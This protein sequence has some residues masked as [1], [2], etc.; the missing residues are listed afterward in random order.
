MRRRQVIARQVDGDDAGLA[1]IAEVRYGV[2]SPAFL[3]E[4]D[5]LIL[6]NFFTRQDGVDFPVPS[7]TGS[8]WAFRA[9]CARLAAVINRVCGAATIEKHRM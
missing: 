3:R 1:R 2:S 6:A 5:E 4:E 9:G 8:R 7:G